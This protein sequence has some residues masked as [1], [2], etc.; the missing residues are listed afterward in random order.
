MASDVFLRAFSLLLVSEELKKFKT[1]IFPQLL[2]RL[3]HEIRQTM[4]SVRQTL[5]VSELKE[6]D[7]KKIWPSAETAMRKRFQ[8]LL[9]A[10]A[11]MPREEKLALLMRDQLDL[12][13]T[14]MS[15]ILGKS[16]KEIHQTLLRAR[17]LLEENVER[18]MGRDTK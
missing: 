2:S 3:V 13:H 1:P 11:S 12:G 6:D 4:E 5:Q 14:E 10:L 18:S 9:K 8:V 16:E 15:R 7:F 17:I